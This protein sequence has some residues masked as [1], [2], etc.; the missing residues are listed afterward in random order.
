MNEKSFTLQIK[1][2]SDRRLEG[3]IH[4]TQN[5]QNFSTFSNN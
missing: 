2:L 3:S 4:K 1:A 5:N